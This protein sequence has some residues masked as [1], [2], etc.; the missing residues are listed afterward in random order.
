MAGDFT[1]N[2][3]PGQGLGFVASKEI[4]LGLGT[5]FGIVSKILVEVIRLFSYITKTISLESRLNDS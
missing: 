5:S 1:M 4:A 3:Q 2:I